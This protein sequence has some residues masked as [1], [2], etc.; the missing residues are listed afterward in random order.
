[1]KSTL[2][3]C[4]AGVEALMGHLYAARI[5]AGEAGNLD[6]FSNNAQAALAST[7]QLLDQ[8]TDQVDRARS[9][10]AA[11]LCSRDSN[12]KAIQLLAEELVAVTAAIDKL[13]IGIETKTNLEAA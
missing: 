6:S 3:E 8:I 9:D 7:R 1:M 10:L 2:D 12:E 5:I 13:R 4:I 11:V